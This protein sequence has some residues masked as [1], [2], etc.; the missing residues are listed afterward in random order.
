MTLLLLCIWSHGMAS[1]SCVNLSSWHHRSWSLVVFLRRLFYPTLCEWNLVRGT[2]CSRHLRLHVWNEVR[3]GRYQSCKSQLREVMSSPPVTTQSK[4]YGHCALVEGR[5]SR[6]NLRIVGCLLLPH[7]LYPIVSLAY[8]WNFN[9][10]VIKWKH[11]PRYCP[12]VRGIHRSPVNSPH[13]GQWRGTSMFSLICV[14]INGWLNNR[15]AGDLRGY[16]TH[17]DVSAMV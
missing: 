2:I 4:D 5:G 9:D 6:S 12:F 14:W 15:E 8:L 7:C 16:R 13:K 1:M 11:F 3:P 10:D 17:Y